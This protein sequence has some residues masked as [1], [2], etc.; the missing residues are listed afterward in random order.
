MDEKNITLSST[1]ENPLP[2]SMLMMYGRKQKKEE[3]EVMH[4]E[5]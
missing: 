3:G 4:H 1:D 2:F 5:R